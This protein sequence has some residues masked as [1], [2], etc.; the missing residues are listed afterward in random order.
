MC[1]MRNQFLAKYSSYYAVADVID[2]A[3]LYTGTVTVTESV[4]YVTRKINQYLVVH[5]GVNIC[6]CRNDYS[7][8][9]HLGYN[10]KAIHNR[11]LI[12]RFM[13]PHGAHLGPKDPGGL[14]VVPMNLAM[15]DMLKNHITINQARN[16]KIYQHIRGVPKGQ[17]CNNMWMM[18]AGMIYVVYT[19]WQNVTLC[20]VRQSRPS[21]KTLSYAHNDSPG[22]VAWIT[23]IKGAVCTGNFMAFVPRRKLTGA[24]VDAMIA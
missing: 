19:K 24:S 15:W 13:G 23:T 16:H 5:T 2:Y 10:W 11:P 8:S 7:S 9:P 12:A 1:C 4:V 22:L 17:K 20:T 6:I 18:K 3:A 14:H 21:A